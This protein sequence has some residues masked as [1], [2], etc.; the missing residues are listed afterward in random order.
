[1]IYYIF[2]FLTAIPVALEDKK[3]ITLP[4]KKNRE[5]TF[6]GY[7][8]LFF[9]TLFVGTRFDVGADYKLYSLNFDNLHSD[10]FFDLF[11]SLWSYTARDV[12]Y[13][14]ISLVAAK[15]NIGF[16]G[17]TLI[18]GF[19]FSYG[20]VKFCFTLSRPWLALLVSIPYVII[21]VGMGYMRQGI[22]LV[23]LMWAIS[24]LIEGRKKE[25]LILVLLGALFHKTLAIFLLFPILLFAKSRLTYIFLVISLFPI[26]YIYYLSEVISGFTYNYI[27]LNQQS[28][29]AFV[30]LLLL[31]LSG[32]LYF[33]FIFSKCYDQI[34]RRLWAYFSIFSFAL[35][36]LYFF[37]DASTAIDRIAL[38]L[39]PLQVFVFSAL[40]DNLLFDKSNK[41]FIWVFFVITL[42]LLVMFVWLSFGVHSVYWMPYQSWIFSP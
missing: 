37:I 31:S 4:T 10:S 27:E 13:E 35:L 26:I 24:Y 39:L 16:E 8:F 21:V 3:E 18:S 5:I 1:M 17:V 12:G 41:N 25:Y 32:A 33:L 36:A 6:L 23:F 15:L 42:Y 29:G 34:E 28:S 20:L 30:R 14:F 7:I 2:F 22:A 9:T 40:P 38:Y 19:I 11:F